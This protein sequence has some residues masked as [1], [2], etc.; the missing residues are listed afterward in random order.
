MDGQAK[1]RTISAM[2]NDLIKETKDVLAEPGKYH[3]DYN[4]EAGY[5]IAG[6]IWFQGYNDLIMPYLCPA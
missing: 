3:P 2:R 4:K 6:F 5:E 1:A